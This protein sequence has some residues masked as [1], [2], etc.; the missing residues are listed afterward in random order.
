MDGNRT[1]CTPII[2]MP[3]LIAFAALAMPEIMPPPADRDNQ[4]S[5]SGWASSISS[6][7]RALAGD[8]FSIV[9]GMHQREPPLRHH[10]QR[11]RFRFVEIFAMQD[12]FRTE[13]ASLST[14]T[15]GVSAASRSL[16]EFPAA[17]A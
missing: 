2:S 12:D 10:L 9:V 8:H 11:M 6:A 3:G 15:F 7:N 1:V 14:F 5:R 4:E 13:G 17:L 16:R